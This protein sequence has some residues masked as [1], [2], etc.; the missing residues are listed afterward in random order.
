MASQFERQPDLHPSVS[1]VFQNSD[2]DAGTPLR[3]S[4]A[5]MSSTRLWDMQDAKVNPLEVTGGDLSVFK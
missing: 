5:K 2:S 1:I 3:E 4:I